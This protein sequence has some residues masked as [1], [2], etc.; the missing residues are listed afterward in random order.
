VSTSSRLRAGL[1]ASACLA[2]L[3]A[4]AGDS[5]DRSTDAPEAATVAPSAKAARQPVRKAAPADL[6]N[7][8][9]SPRGK[10]H[11]WG[12][13]G[14]LTNYADAPMLYSLTV[15]TVGA[16][17]EVLGERDGSFTLKPNQ[18]RTFT[19]PRFYQG[20]AEACLPRVLRRPA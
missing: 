6:A 2:I 10:K 13:R 4:C 1:V 19:W 5:P 18:T 3:P 11:A 7:F 8:A 16:G 17:D 12:A 15:V 20:P 14:D 9:C